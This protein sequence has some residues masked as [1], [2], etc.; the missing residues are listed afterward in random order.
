MDKITFKHQPQK[1]PFTTSLNFVKHIFGDNW[2]WGLDYLS[3]IYTKP[4]IDLPAL[5]LIDKTGGGTGKSTF[6]F[7]LKELFTP[8]LVMTTNEEMRGEINSDYATKLLAVLDEGFIDQELCNKI[9][10]T[11]TGVPFKITGKGYYQV[12]EKS[13]T[14]F[15]VT[16]NSD[17]YMIS[18]L[19]PDYFWLI[20]MKPFEKED[21]LMLFKLKKEIHAFL[22]FLETRKISNF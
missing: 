2:R 20:R 6:V 17:P 14:K 19:D 16:A 5:V 4:D 10:D 15:I 12:G 11:M 8:N 21:A 1:G 9:L 7:W 18:A 3:I 22:F 13:R